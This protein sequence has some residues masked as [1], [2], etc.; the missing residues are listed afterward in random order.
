MFC[1]D[2]I[3]L[4]IFPPQHSDGS[5]SQ[6]LLYSYYVKGCMLTVLR[7]NR[8]SERVFI[9]QASCVVTSRQLSLFSFHQSVLQVLEIF[10][11]ELSKFTKA[12]SSRIPVH[13]NSMTGGLHHASQLAAFCFLPWLIAGKCFSTFS[14]LTQSFSARTGAQGC[15]THYRHRTQY[16]VLDSATDFSIQKF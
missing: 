12:P 7:C 9:F 3:S 1:V 4:L 5:S 11:T 8:R 13:F 15:S 6:W 2:L 10:T 14:A 16:F